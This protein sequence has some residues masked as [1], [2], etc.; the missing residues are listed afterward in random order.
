MKRNLKVLLIAAFL[1]TAP[2]LILAQPHPNGG[3]N[4][5]AGGTTNNPV[6]PSAPIGN[7]T[8]ILLVLAA[9]YGSRKVYEARETAG[10]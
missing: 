5:N 3:N 9:A 1:V 2:L 6:G 8:I 7:G 4:P 10:E